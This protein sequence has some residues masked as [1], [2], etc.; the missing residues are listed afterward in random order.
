MSDDLFLRGADIAIMCILLLSSENLCIP[1]CFLNLPVLLQLWCWHYL[2]VESCYKA[3]FILYE[4][5]AEMHT[6]Y[7]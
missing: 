3:Y 2:Q 5:L 1:I 6:T 4:V 7:K